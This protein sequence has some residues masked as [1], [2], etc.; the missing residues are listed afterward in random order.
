[1]THIYR[2]RNLSHRF[3]GLY[4]LI[5]WQSPN[6]SRTKLRA[7]DIETETDLTSLLTGVLSGVQR[8]PGA[9]AHQGA[10]VT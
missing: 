2:G 6:V 7:V 8:L 3:D 5:V 4:G 1:M 9:A 10:S